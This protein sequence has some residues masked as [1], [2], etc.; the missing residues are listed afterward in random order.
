[1]DQVFQPA[2]PGRGKIRLVPRLETGGRIS[3]QAID[4]RLGT[5][6]KSLFHT[7]N[8]IL[9]TGNCS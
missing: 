8:L 5:L 9:P 7:Y 4:S 1:M 3:L 2:S 6:S